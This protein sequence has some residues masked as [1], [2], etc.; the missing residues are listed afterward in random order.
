VWDFLFEYYPLSPAKLTAWHP[1]F[2]VVL[3]GPP[4]QTYLRQPGYRRVP[5][6]VTADPGSLTGRRPRLALAI[7]I[8]H[9]TLTRPA[10]TGCFA[11]H[12]WAMVYRLSQDE[13][14]HAQL[15]LRLSPEDIASAVE[16]IG[17]RCTHIDAFRFFTPAAVPLN[18]LVPTRASQPQLEQPGCLHAAMDLYKMTAWFQP[19]TSSDLLLD[20][21]E[22][23]ARAREL[24]MR[25]SP[26]D[27]SAFGMAPIRVETPE[28]RREYAKAQADLRQRTDPLRRR[29]LA[30]LSEIQAAMDSVPEQDSRPGDEGVAGGVNDGAADA[31]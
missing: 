12:E 15:P 24:D 27:V 23:A 21:F 5:G 2:G 6:G 9:G 31:V 20:T 3:E 4:A 17:L 29:L 7:G 13:V 22:N 30:D 19:L 11:L 26:Y 28:G 25:S 8:L 1:G 14:R 16:T 10:V 18:A